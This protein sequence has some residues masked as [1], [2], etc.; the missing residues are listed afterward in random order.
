MAVAVA[1]MRRREVSH[2][3]TMVHNVKST[4]ENITAIVTPSICTRPRRRLNMQVVYANIP[5]RVFVPPASIRIMHRTFNTVPMTERAIDG[6]R[7][8]RTIR[9]V[10]V[11]MDIV[12]IGVRFR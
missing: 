11:W 8:G 4:R 6:Y 2:F 5:P 9:D 1:V 7:T 3:V 10:A 12:V